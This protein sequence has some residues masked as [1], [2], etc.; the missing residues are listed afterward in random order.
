MLAAMVLAFA[1]GEEWREIGQP[2]LTAGQQILGRERI[3]EFLEPLGITALQEGIG[4]LP[5]VD[6]LFAHPVSE[7]VMLVQADP[8]SKREIRADSHKDPAPAS[9]VHIEVVLND[10][11][12]GHLQIPP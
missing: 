11:A 12:L 7:P 3:G 5:E 8:S 4:T 6:L 2:L 10:P 1:L 9:I